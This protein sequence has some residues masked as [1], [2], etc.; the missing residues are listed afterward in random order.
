MKNKKYLSLLL[1]IL[2]I[3]FAVRAFL[4]HMEPIWL[5]EQYSLLFATQFSS[6]E[7]ISGFSKDVH[8]G[9]YYLILKISLNFSTN[10]FF[11]RLITGVI[12]QIA[13]IFILA[14]ALKNNKDNLHSLLLTTIIITNPFFIHLSW[15][16]RSYGFIFLLVSA[17]YFL[18]KKL[19]KKYS[20]RNTFFLITLILIG[21]MTHYGMY[22]FGF[23]VGIYFLCLK[24]NTSFKK[25]FFLSTTLASIF[26]FQFL[27]QNNFHSI[28]QYK[29][30][31][32]DIQWIEKPSI[33]NIQHVYMSALGFK[34]DN[35]IY[36]LKN[37]SYL[38]IFIRY[39]LIILFI[40]FVKRNLKKEKTK[41]IIFIFLPFLSI[42]SI[43]LLF[44]FLSERIFFN[45]FIPNISIFIPRMHL[46]FVILL[47]VFLSK[48]ILNK[49]PF[50]NK[51]IKILS[52]IAALSVL[53]FWTYIIQQ[54][55]VQT[56]KPV[57]EQRANIKKIMTESIAS[58]KQLYI[59]PHWIFLETVE[60]NS[61][62]KIKKTVQLQQLSKE[63]EN[64]IS[65]NNTL[66]CSELN[67]SQFYIYSKWVSSQFVLREK[68]TSKLNE[69]CKE[70]E[71]IGNFEKWECPKP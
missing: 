32:N 20:T 53:F 55:Y 69:C 3:G 42:L 40:Y 54:N 63:F 56:N 36:V 23:F 68:I 27:I 7:L 31:F 38:E 67:D 8:P 26:I 70:K 71:K 51:K 44:P 4:A 11:L 49:W 41:I 30:V 45:K 13:G 12:P 57:L 21:N 17:S 37:I 1:P 34:T 52:V 62:E 47:W 59:W 39:V 50:L 48:L 18:I 60:P 65:Q 9:L 14:Q 35:Q 2:A 61:L 64:N 28:N 19:E 22:L 46:P 25:K 33:Q 10:I 5:D 15:Q 58:K 29:S 16:L 66:L 43:S 6:S 24:S